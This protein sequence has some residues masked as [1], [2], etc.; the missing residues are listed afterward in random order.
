MISQKDDIM[1]YLKSWY[2][3]KMA[4]QNML[5][6]NEGNFFCHALDLIKCLKQIK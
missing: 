5:R 4:I 1:F 6:T 3:Y 2:L